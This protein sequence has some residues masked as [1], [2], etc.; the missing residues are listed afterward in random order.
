MTSECKYNDRQAAQRGD[1]TSPMHN[2]D[3]PSVLHGVA[4]DKMCHHENY[5]VSY[6]YESNHAGIFERVQAPQ[7]GQGN[8]DKP[9][10]ILAL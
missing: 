9:T 4:F 3:G 1:H 6:G 10:I 5:K 7:E 2:P 8:N